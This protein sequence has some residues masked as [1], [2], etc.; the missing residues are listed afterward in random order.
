VQQKSP[1][2]LGPQTSAESSA[3]GVTPPVQV[4]STAAT[5]AQSGAGATQTWSTQRFEQQS[6]AEAQSDPFATQGRGAHIWSTQLHEQQSSGE[7]QAAPF[8]EQAG[9][10]APQVAGAHVAPSSPPHCPEQHGD[11]GPHPAPR[12]WQATHAGGRTRELQQ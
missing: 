1:D 9:G 12:A 10:V 6:P 5:V 3:A 8:W 2:G 4:Y 7:E 11:P